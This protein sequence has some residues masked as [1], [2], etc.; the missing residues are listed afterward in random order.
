MVVLKASE[1]PGCGMFVRGYFLQWMTFE[2]GLVLL[3][4]IAAIVLFATDRLPFDVV[5]LLLLTTLLLFGILTPTEAFRGFGSDTVIIIGGL[6][7]M[8][9]AVLRTGV[10]DTIAGAL[11]RWAG[12][13]AWWMASL[14]MITVSAVSSFVSNTAATAFFLPAVIVIARRINTSPSL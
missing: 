4:L 1:V 3:L 12:D 11:Q 13:N 14:I 6:F 8:T 10:M 7:V 5:A 9:H 2:I